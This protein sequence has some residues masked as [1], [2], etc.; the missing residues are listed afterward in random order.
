MP[1]SK[2]RS[3]SAKASSSFSPLPKNSGADP[4]PPKFPQPRPRR[5]M[6]RPVVPSRRYS[7]PLLGPA[8][9]PSGRAR[10][11]NMAALE[12]NSQR[13]EDAVRKS[14]AAAAWLAASTSLAGPPSAIVLDNARVRVFKTIT[15]RA[16]SDHPAAVVVVLEDGATRKAGDAYWSGDAAAAKSG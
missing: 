2:A 15:A 14:F 8:A 16:A 4:I 12:R 9:R 1:A 7:M 10:G 3:I 6:R 13:E 11:Y 5:E